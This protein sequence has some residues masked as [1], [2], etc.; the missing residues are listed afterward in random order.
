MFYVQN[1]KFKFCVPYARSS[2]YTPLL[3][4]STHSRALYTILSR[5]LAPAHPN[6]ARLRAIPPVD[7]TM[8]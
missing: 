1:F 8:T 4:T 7:Q 3:P 2:L 5:L 6:E